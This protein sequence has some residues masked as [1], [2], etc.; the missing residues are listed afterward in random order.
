MP[1][2]LVVGQADA[3]GPMP[4]SEFAEMLGRRTGVPRLPMPERADAFEASDWIATDLAGAFTEPLFRKAET[5]VWLHFSPLPFLAD[6]LA[7]QWQRIKAFPYPDQR[8][9][10]RARWNDVVTAFLHLVQA[11][12]MYEL[13]RHPALA[14][15]RVVELRTPRQAEF[16]LMT[17]DPPRK[18]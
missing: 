12:K 17:Q 3:A 7:H 16:W 13:F 18:R 5:V 4:C 11:H 15:I 8:A 6:C 9:A 14:H 10:M 1:R 2:F